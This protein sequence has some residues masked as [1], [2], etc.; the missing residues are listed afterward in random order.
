MI[1]A[2]PQATELRVTFALAGT[3]SAK[4]DAVM[5]QTLE[6]KVARRLPAVIG[7]SPGYGASFNIAP[8]AASGPIFGPPQ[9]R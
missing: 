8:G 3:G 2:V 9:T 7:A 6:E 5:V 1:R 4:V